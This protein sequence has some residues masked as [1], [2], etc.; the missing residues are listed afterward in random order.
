L[1][2]QKDMCNLQLWAVGCMATT[3]TSADSSLSYAVALVQPGHLPSNLLSHNQQVQLAAL[4]R[5]NE[6]CDRANKLPSDKQINKPTSQRA[7]TIAHATA[8]ETEAAANAIVW[9]SVFG[10]TVFVRCHR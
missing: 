4:V 10:L 6:A 9:H 8:T 1:A 2:S 7:N 3:P 5:H